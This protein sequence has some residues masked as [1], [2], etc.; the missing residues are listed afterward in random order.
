VNAEES[1]IPSSELALDAKPATAS[2]ASEAV[3]EPVTEAKPADDAS[4]WGQPLALYTQVF[5]PAVMIGLGVSYRPMQSLAVD[6][7]VGWFTTALFERSSTEGV[8]PA[9]GL[10][11]LLG[12][13]NHCLE[14]GATAAVMI[15][16]GEG[17]RALPVFGPHLGYRYQPVDGGLFLRMTVHGVV[18]RSFDKMTPWP[19]V[20]F[21]M[22]WGT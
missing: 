21:G 20:G 3:T 18:A 8:T 15:S 9:L 13:R 5:G 14:L 6:A 22:T 1:T 10:A 11:W 7:S 2:A 16:S 19:G 17:E 4:V 12:R